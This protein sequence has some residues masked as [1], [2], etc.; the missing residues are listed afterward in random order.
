MK[1]MIEDSL[2]TFHNALDR[3]ATLKRLNERWVADPRFRASLAEDP[4]GTLARYAIPCTVATLARCSTA[5]CPSPRR[6][7]CGRSSRPSRTG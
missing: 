4:S 6:P 3:H 7:G 1:P 2:A 5:I